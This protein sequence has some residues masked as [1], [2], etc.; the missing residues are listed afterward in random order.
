MNIH[1]HCYV[2][3]LGAVGA[4]STPIP[5]HPSVLSSN[6][7]INQINNAQLATQM[8]CGINP[9]ALGNNGSGAQ[10]NNIG[11]NSTIQ[12]SNYT[13]LTNENSSKYL[14]GAQNILPLV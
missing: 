8:S 10:T 3:P 13:S 7:N 12:G 9:L 14:V 6:T 2:L 1:G 11:C 5:H 4:S